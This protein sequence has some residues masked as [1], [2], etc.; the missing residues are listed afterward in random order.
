MK[1]SRLF[2]VRGEGGRGRFSWL[3]MLAVLLGTAFLL[4]F[5]YYWR[6]ND[7]SFARIF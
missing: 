6:T 3:L 4:A 1:L 5:D 2:W 7:T